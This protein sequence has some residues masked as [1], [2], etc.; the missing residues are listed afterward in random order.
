MFPA[1]AHDQ[2]SAVVFFYARVHIAR[3]VEFT[4]FS[5][6]VDVPAAW[7]ARDPQ[8]GLFRYARTGLSTIQIS[9]TL[10]TAIAACR[11]GRFQPLTNEERLA[12]EENRLDAPMTPSMQ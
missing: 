4:V 5:P 12:R 1:F 9:S 3:R 10:S 6:H 8:P 11:T 7:P 2:I